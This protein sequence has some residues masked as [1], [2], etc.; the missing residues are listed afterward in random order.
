M[1]LINLGSVATAALEVLRWR[2]IP[3]TR[4]AA[5]K[6]KKKNQRT[7][8]LDRL[9]GLEIVASDSESPDVE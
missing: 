7:T 1:D 4:N 5:K 6:K 2:F 8:N 3:G 9:C